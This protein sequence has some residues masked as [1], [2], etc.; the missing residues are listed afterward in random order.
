MYLRTV[1]AKGVE[2]VQLAHNEWINGSSRARII[3]GFG[4]KDRK[5]SMWVCRLGHEVWS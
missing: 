4:R 3:R 1:K 5:L 2:Y